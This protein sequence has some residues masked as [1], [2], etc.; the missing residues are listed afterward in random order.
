MEPRVLARM[1][2]VAGAELG[3]WYRIQFY[4]SIVFRQPFDWNNQTIRS[5]CWK[6]LSAKFRFNT[7]EHIVAIVWTAEETMSMSNAITGESPIQRL[8]VIKKNNKTNSQKLTDADEK[9]KN[10][11]AEVSIQFS[12]IK[13]V[14]DKNIARKR[15]KYTRKRE[16]ASS[17]FTMS[18]IQ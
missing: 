12:R 2:R 6:T 8:N 10:E 9:N 15:C 17:E 4:L 7:M 14:F 1:D 13:K 3:Q 16:R 11:F 18:S 5:L